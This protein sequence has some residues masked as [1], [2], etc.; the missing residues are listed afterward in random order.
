MAHGAKPMAETLENV[1]ELDLQIPDSTPTLFNH[2]SY[3]LS[4][5][6]SDFPVEVNETLEKYTRS[7]SID[8]PL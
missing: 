2:K 1:Q 8:F 5:E 6:L 7:L 4:T 3:A